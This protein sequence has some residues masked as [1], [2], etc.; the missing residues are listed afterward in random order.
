[1]S[2]RGC[3]L[4][5]I[6]VLALAGWGGS[7]AS[8]LPPPAPVPTAAL[9]SPDRGGDD[10]LILDLALDRRPLASGMT[11]YLRRGGVLLPLGEVARALEFAIE[12]DPGAGVASGWFLRENRRFSLTMERREV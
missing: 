12:V 4:L 11:G 5:T 9:G 7:I 8:A 1:M 10:L 6:A 3:A 2:G